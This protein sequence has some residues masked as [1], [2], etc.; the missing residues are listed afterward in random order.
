MKN[1]L[2]RV[3]ALSLTL[4]AC[5]PGLFDAASEYDPARE[6][7]AACGAITHT[8]EVLTP[9]KA[10]MS[11]TQRQLVTNAV[12]NSEPVCTADDPP[13]TALAA[14]E[15]LLSNLKYVQQSMIEE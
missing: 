7:I 4:T 2:L 11:D 9:Y 1:V 13:E 5:S 6:V 3:S 8:V 15:D 10:E 14:L 12:D